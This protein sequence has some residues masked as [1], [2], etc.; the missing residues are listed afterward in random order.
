MN[1][2]TAG[3]NILDVTEHLWKACLTDLINTMHLALVL[4]DEDLVIET[5]GGHTFCDF[6]LGHFAQWLLWH[7]KHF[8]ALQVSFLIFLWRVAKDL[9]SLN[10][11]ERR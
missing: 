7:V 8:A 5:S 11:R 10:I 2:D 4:E 1:E 9:L 6:E 3:C